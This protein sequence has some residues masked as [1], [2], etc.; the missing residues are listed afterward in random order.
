LQGNPGSQGIQ[1]P[2]GPTGPTGLTPAI[3]GS[4]THIQYNNNGS[5]SGDSNLTWTASGSG[6]NLIVGGSDGTANHGIVSRFFN[7][8]SSGTTIYYNVA[9]T[10]ISFDIASG[11][12]FRIANNGDVTAAGDVIAYGVSDI[13]LKNNIKVIDK[14]LNKVL[15]LEG[16]TYNW[17]NIAAEKIEKSTTE[18]ESGIIAQQVKEVLPEAVSERADGYLGVRYE[19]L[20]PLLVQAI[21]E[22]KEEVEEL[23]N[24]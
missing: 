3:G 12:K 15:Q 5:L 14:A 2:T 22:L 6:R 23:K 7:F 16:I 18:R 20:I 11:Q 24:R 17:N 10:W 13:R 8:N 4:T 21:K 1:G 19:K 9:S